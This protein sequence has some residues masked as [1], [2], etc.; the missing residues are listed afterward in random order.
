MTTDEEIIQLL[1]EIRDAQARHQEEW[2]A[3]VRKAEDQQQ[4]ALR[5]IAKGKRSLWLF[6]GLAVL[7]LVG[8]PYLPTMFRC[9]PIPENS[10]ELAQYGDP[11]ATP[12]FD[13]SYILD[14]EASLAGLRKRLAEARL[15]NQEAAQ[16]VLDMTEK[17]FDNF[18]INHGVITSGKSLV[19]EFR[20]VS[21]TM[22]D[23]QLH[24]RAIWHEDIHDPGD[25]TAVNVHLSLEG[26]TLKFSYHPDGERPP[27]DPIVLRRGAP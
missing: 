23:G 14:R 8:I 4:R 2:R 17:Q 5:N 6:L 18:R 21:G 19:Q 24:G 26:N 27:E 7:I 11:I 9:T 20:L 10:P 25:F 3:T 22:N 12:I 1:C 15:E 13:G 16:S